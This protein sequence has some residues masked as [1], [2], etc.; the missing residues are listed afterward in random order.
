MSTWPPDAWKIG[1]GTVW[2]GVSYDPEQNLIYHGTGNPGPWNPAQRPGD[3][4]W[5]CGIFARDADTGEAVW[6]YPVWSITE[7]F[8]VWSG[9]VVTAGDVVFYGTMDGNFKAVDARTGEVLWTYQSR[10]GNHQPAGFVSRA[11]RETVHRGH[12]GRW[13]LVWRGCGGRARH[14]RFDRRARLRECDEGPAA[15]QSVGREG[16]CV[17]AP[18]I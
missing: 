12:G 3:N 5:T 4:K 17:F 9:T 1:G 14:A 11:G 7:N 6:F 18:V 2:G 10:V 15:I 16:L 8:P 13:W